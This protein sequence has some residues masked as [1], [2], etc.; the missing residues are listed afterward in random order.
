MEEEIW[1]TRYNIL[2]WRSYIV[3]TTKEFN[4]LPNKK[5]IFSG[6]LSKESPLSLSRFCCNA[7][8]KGMPR[9]Y[10]S[11]SSKMFAKVQTKFR[12]VE[13]R[14]KFFPIIWSTTG[15]SY[16]LFIGQSKIDNIKRT[17]MV[18][19]NRWMKTNRVNA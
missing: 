18:T 19:L 4:A 5:A 16:T 6:Y 3:C 10:I 11:I 15:F 8:R 14:L 12:Y 17:F 13:E 1:K 2:A 9:E 7:N